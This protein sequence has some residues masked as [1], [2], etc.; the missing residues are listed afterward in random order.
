[1]EIKNENKF[2]TFFKR[3]GAIT[4]ACVFS[5]VVALVIALSVV[6]RQ[7]VEEV[8]TTN[9]TFSLPMNNAVVIKDYSDTELQY[10]ST[11]N[12]WEIH[13][14]V[15]LS[16]ENASV[17]S[18][19]DGVVSSVESN[20]L[21]GCI[22]TIKHD[23]GFVSVYSSLADNLTVKEGDKI[24]KG[25]KIGQASETATNEIKDGAHLHF[26][27]LKDNVEVDPNNYLDLQNK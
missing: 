13:L 20:S 4:M 25:Q 14:G 11:L 5:L 19:L 26:V 27:L 10:N 2:K 12:R 1:M 6:Q 9:L 22:V 17:F 7:D 15:D 18:V 24:S 3:Y 23:N 21:E 8:S 16:S